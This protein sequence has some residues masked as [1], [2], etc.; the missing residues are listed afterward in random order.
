[1]IGQVEG[2]QV[3]IILDVALAAVQR[4]LRAQ[5]RPELAITKETLLEQFVADG[6]LL[7]DKGQK[8]QP[9]DRGRRV[10]QRRI[11]RDG[12]RTYVAV[13]PAEVFGIEANSVP[14]LPLGY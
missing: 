5:G 11:R 14:R 9:Q 12:S 2:G 6:L 13:L 3:E 7:N 8:I 1:L 10:F 4:A